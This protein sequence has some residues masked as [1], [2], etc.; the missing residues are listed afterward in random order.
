MK[1]WKGDKRWAD[2]FLPE[3]KRILGE[4]FIEEP[5]IEEDT[6]RNTDLIVL[7]LNALRFGCRIRRNS[8]L[9]D[10]ANEFT[11][12]EG[13]PSGAKTEL[14]KIIEGW[15]D[16]MFY[17]FADEGEVSLAKWTVLDFKVFR[18]WY[19]RQLASGAMPGTKEINADKSSWF[20][21][22][23]IRGIP[24]IAYASQG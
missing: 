7:K 17:G 20:R 12:R 16:Y 8:Y 22:F 10:Y 21:A 3:I 23:D 14:T 19:M 11:I 13:R 2:R 18:L 1:D 24:N 6:E 15:G 4:L 9:K 5:A